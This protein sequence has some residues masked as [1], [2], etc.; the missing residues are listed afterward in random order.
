MTAGRAWVG[1]VWWALVG[2]VVALGVAGQVRV[3]ASDRG[4]WND[5]LYL[6]VNVRDK[7]FRGLTGPLRY[8]QVAP[9]GWLAGEK[10]MYRLFG[11]DEQVLRLPQ[12]VAAAAVLVLT[13]VVA[14]RALGRWGALAATALAILLMADVLFRA[15]ARPWPG[16]VLVFA[17]VTTLA[18]FVSYSALLVLAGVTAGLLGALAL[19]RQWRA[20]VIAVAAAAPA[21]LLG[22][23]LVYRRMSFPFLSNQA[24]FFTTGLPPE[25]AGPVEVLRWLPDL[26]RGFVASPLRWAYP[27]LVLGLMLAGV[28]ALVLRGRPLWAA[29]LVGVFG[30]AVGAAALGRLPMEDRVALYLVAPAAIAVAA[31]FDGA[32]RALVRA[33]RY[34]RDG[35]PRAAGDAPP[36]RA[37]QGVRRRVAVAVALAL[38]VAVPGMVL[39][40]R[41]AV[42]AAVDEVRHPRYRDVGRDV[43]RDVA[44][45]VR[46]GDVVLVYGFSQ[47]IASWYGVRHRLPMAGLVSAVAMNACQ[48]ATVDAVLA[49]AARVW[50]VHGAKWSRHPDDYHAYVVAQLARR[51]RIA[52]ARVFGQAGHAPGWVLVDLSQGPDPSPPAP[53]PQPAYACLT[54]QPKWR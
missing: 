39:A 16:P 48:P 50:Y 27:W 12:L 19:G 13:A 52:A 23:Y 14:Y 29:M 35:Q 45:Q 36:A 49:G 15:R 54:V 5:E 43:M 10:V 17:V 34:D 53:A 24:G 20:A 33:V 51:G 46:P 25:G 22:G 47:P 9:P 1:R 30:A 4:F 37:V 32:A 18:V 7:G 42:V 21:A 31:A 3:W 6:A 28:V 2:L 8:A 44:G 11:G 38:L 40:V 41:P 26:W